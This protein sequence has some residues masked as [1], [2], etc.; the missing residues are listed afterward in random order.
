MGTATA[1]EPGTPIPIVTALLTANPT[2]SSQAPTTTMAAVSI[3]TGAILS[4]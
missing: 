2:I 4:P 3:I 1:Q